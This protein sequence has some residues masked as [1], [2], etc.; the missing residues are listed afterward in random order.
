MQRSGLQA[1]HDEAKG[2]L[3]FGWKPLTKGQGTCNEVAGKQTT[4]K[5]RET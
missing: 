2:I 4:M 1:V 5:Q 3:T